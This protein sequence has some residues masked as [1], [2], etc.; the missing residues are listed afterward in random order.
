MKFIHLEKLDDYAKFHNA[1]AETI[2]DTVLADFGFDEDGKKT[3]NVGLSVITVSRQNDLTIALF[4]E[5]AGKT[6]KS[7][8][9]KIMTLIKLPKLRKI[10]QT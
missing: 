7:I 5:I 9:K 8:S 4:D 3:F 6:V 10:Y 2:R 1:D